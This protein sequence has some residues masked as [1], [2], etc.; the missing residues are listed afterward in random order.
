MLIQPLLYIL[1]IYPAGVQRKFIDESGTL[2]QRSSGIVCLLC[3]YIS[4]I[5]EMLSCLVRHLYTHTHM[6][7]VFP[8]I[9]L[10]YN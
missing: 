3:I 7:Y 1:C 6:F 4:S 9:R 2:V 5:L 8:W 10:R